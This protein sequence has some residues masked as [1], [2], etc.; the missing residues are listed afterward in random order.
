MYFSIADIHVFLYH[1]CK[2]NAFNN[3]TISGEELYNLHA[4]VLILI[5]YVYIVYVCTNKVE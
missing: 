2:E 5:L 3:I 4:F 1:P